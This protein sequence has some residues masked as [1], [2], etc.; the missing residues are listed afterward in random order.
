MKERT[1]LRDI[2][3]EAGVSLT[4]VS[5]TL[6][7]KGAISEPTRSKVMSAAEQL[8]YQQR[9]LSAPR[10]NAQL[11]TLTMLIKRDPNEKA[12]NPFHYYVMQG[13]E[14]QCKQLGLELRFSSLSVDENSRI[15]ELPS[16][17]DLRNTDGFLIVGAVVEDGGS[18]LATLGER[19][20]VFIN[21]YLRGAS[22]D[23]VEIDNRAGAYDAAAYLVTQGHKHIGFV[24]GGE[25]VHPSISE[26][27]EGYE[28]AL[29]DAQIQT[30]YCAD[31]LVLTPDYAADAAKGLLSAHPNITALV[32]AS[33]NVAMG[34]Y[35]AAEAL[36]LKVPGDLSVV[37][38]DNIHGVEH[39]TPPL[40]T[41]HIDKEYLGAAAVRHLY[42]APLNERP[43]VAI[44]VRP[45][46]VRRDS[47]ATPAQRVEGAS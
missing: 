10:L 39:L 20:V 24:G 33:D 45:E 43:N 41:M 7:N 14:A 46:L 2:A 21:G 27:R 8:G 37:G 42:D 18:F 29:A 26:R 40:T 17:T 38:F 35:R 4:T 15:L 13:I 11:N 16:A 9:V 28:K 3:E 1:T 5:Q 22:Y 19:P 6:N 32:A 30:F 12:P 36:D 47:V 25:G 34:I 44:L 23:R 31:S